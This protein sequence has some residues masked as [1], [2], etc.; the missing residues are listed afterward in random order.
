MPDIQKIKLDFQSL[1]IKSKKNPEMTEEELRTLFIKTAILENLGYSVIGKDIR[2]ELS[3]NGKRSDIVCLDDFGNVVFVIEFKKPSDNV[4]LKEH[5]DQLW[6]RYVKPLRADFGALINGYELIFYKRIGENNKLELRVNL[7]EISDK[8]CQLIYNF[9]KKP[10]YSLT[11]VKD[12]LNYLNKFSAP[13]SR[14]YLI[15]DAAREHFFENFKLEDDSIFGGMLKNMIELFDYEKSHSKFLISAYDFWRK[16]YAKKPDKVPES[17]KKLLKGAGLTTSEEDLYKFMF[18]LETTYALFTRLIL[19]KACEDYDFQGIDF[20]EFIENEIKGS[21]RRGGTFLVVWGVLV[22]RLIRKMRRDLVESVFEEDLFYWWTDDFEGLQN[23]I[24]TDMRSYEVALMDFSRALA[25]VL[26]ALYKFDFSKIIGDPLGD[27]YQKYFDRETR[28]ALGEFYTPKEVVEYIVDAVDYRGR[29]II[30][31]RLLDPACGSGTF[32]VDALKRYLV[33]ATPLAEEKGWDFVLSK[34]CNEYHIV[35]FDIHPFATIMA[36]IQF[37]L[38]LIPKYKEALKKNGNF[39][40]KRLPIFRTDSL[41]DES[42]SEAMTLS[43]FEGGRSVSFKITLPVRA[44]DK[45]VDAEVIMPFRGEAISEKTGLLNIPEYFA[46]LQALF[47][48]VKEAARAEPEKQVIEKDRLESSLKLYL[49]NKDWAKLAGF[50]MPYGRYFLDTIKKLKNEYGDGRLV[51]SIE[52]IILAGLL[53]N[54]VEYDFVVGNPPYVRLHNLSDSDRSYYQ[55]NYVSAFKQYDLYV[56]FI[57]RGIKWL[58]N[59]GKFGYIV[60]SKFTSSDY[61]LKLREF[62]LF[63]CKIEQIIDVS[64]FSIFKDASIYPFMII[65]KQESD[66]HQRSSNIIKVAHNVENEKIFTER[67]FGLFEIPQKRFLENQNQIFDIVPVGEHSIISKIKQ[68]FFSLGEKTEIT[69]GFRP[70]P[71]ELIFQEAAYELIPEKEKLELK[72]LIIGSDILGAYR[73]NWT[74]IL[75]RYDMN[76]IFESKPK[77]VFEQPK[78]M[79]RDIGLHASACYDEDNLYCLKTIYLILRKSGS[80]LDLKLITALLNS[81]LIEFYFKSNFWSSHIGGGYLRFR[82]QYLEQL[83]IHLPKTPE[84]QTF[85]SRITTCVEQILVRVKSDQRADRFPEEYIKEFRA[86]GEE[87]DAIEIVFNANHKELAADIEKTLD[88]EYRVSIKSTAPIVAD[89]EIKAEYLKTALAG[90]KVSKGEKIQILVPRADALA[91][92]AVEQHQKDVVEARGIEALED[93]I[94]E[95]VYKLYG[96]DENDKKV[97]EEFLS[98][99]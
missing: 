38:V 47:D 15:T 28:K 24:Y 36:Q 89:S 10:D 71:Q 1:Y 79:I 43:M 68:D 39:V 18:C 56:L 93:E 3:I 92:E 86:R 44:G 65:F 81:K 62:I 33:E 78:I 31:K 45:F 67:K 63:N 82:K 16:S 77:D 13:E 27:L 57:E 91:K 34:L 32:L 14:I 35:G 84:E 29:G 49:P 80:T 19:A 66:I 20:S 83:P 60:S 90:R 85:A 26:Y 41:I 17:W 37:M 11:K 61:G 58:K 21:E 69:R 88:K 59:E 72:K 42:K 40:L 74:G 51:K 12:I 87:F 50:F 2:L 5:F 54:Y 98:K 73:I 46:A 64:N 99:F 75:L 70:P 52:D 95:L 76:K 4:D 55:E 6:D 9:L 23:N 96:L 30:D 97:I 48:T 7:S 8:D 25:K 94:N 22:M 53:K